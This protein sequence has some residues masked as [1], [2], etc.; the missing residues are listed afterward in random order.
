[1]PDEVV[2]EASDEEIISYCFRVYKFE[3]EAEALMTYANTMCTWS[4]L[5][6]NSMSDEDIQNWITDAYKHWKNHDFN[7][8]EQNFV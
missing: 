2:K 5:L 4:T 8:L 1:M 3:T 7:W 6:D